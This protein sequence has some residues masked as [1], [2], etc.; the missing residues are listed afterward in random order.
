MFLQQLPFLGDAVFKDPSALHSAP[1]FVIVKDNSFDGI[2]INI[3]ENV[4]GHP[5]LLMLSVCE[6][7][8]SFFITFY[9]LIIYL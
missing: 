7:F 1:I 6:K 2:K 4:M 5:A 3:K 9:I 8:F